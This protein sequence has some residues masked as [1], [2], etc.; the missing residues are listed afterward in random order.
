MMKLLGKFITNLAEKDKPLQKD[1][2]LVTGY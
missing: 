2:D 1:I